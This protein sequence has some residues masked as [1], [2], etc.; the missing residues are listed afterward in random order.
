MTTGQQNVVS[1]RVTAWLLAVG[2]VSF[3]CAVLLSMFGGG[4]GP[5]PSAGANGYSVSAIGHR[6]LAETLRSLGIQVVLSRHR[7]AQRAGS[8]ALLVVAEP[9][10]SSE[11]AKD[12]R[13]EFAAA[14]TILLV[15]PKWRG[16]A[17]ALNPLWVERT[18][19]LPETTVER[20]LRAVASDA[21]ITRIPGSLTFSAY[22][23]Q[24][25][26][27]SEVE[28]QVI[29][30]PA[31]EARIRAGGG[32]LVGE[33]QTGTG[34]RIVVVSDPDILSNHGLGRDDN[35]A[36]VVS[37]IEEL[38]PPGAP[39]I[40]DE[41]VH[42]FARR[43]SVWQP[44][45]EV[46]LV[47]PTALAGIAVAFALWGGTGRFGGPIPVPKRLRAGKRDLIA[48]AA[49]LLALGGHHR[50]TL[51]RYFAITL[52][53]VAARLNA[54]SGL[55]QW[56]MMDWAD[57]LAQRRGLACRIRPLGDELKKLTAASRFDADRALY[58]AARLHRW[59]KDMTDGC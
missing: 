4:L 17:G 30:S 43:P 13:T 48:N 3:T 18:R 28:A 1:R 16:R 58:L 26:V 19:L 8:A 56:K 37:L 15:L 44:L 14:D 54:P 21:S 33:V 42:G 51:Q 49:D 31:M 27:G 7:S 20:V 34:Q 40:F 41:V 57:R 45:F 32:I 35:A 29:N 38:R 39:V 12:L 46:P 2:V 25:S 55:D 10:L 47:V 23:L 9:Q 53:G 36:I 22:G 59:S 52:R 50:E 5:G 11:D 6:A 24:G